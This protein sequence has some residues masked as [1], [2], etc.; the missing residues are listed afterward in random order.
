LQRGQRTANL[1]IEIFVRNAQCC[2]RIIEYRDDRDVTHAKKHRLRCRQIN[3][4]EA[5]EVRPHLRWKD[6]QA[7]DNRHV[8]FCPRVKG[9]YDTMKMMQLFP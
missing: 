1:S 6:T 4:V 5:F 3:E 9:S 2:L 8:Q 7:T